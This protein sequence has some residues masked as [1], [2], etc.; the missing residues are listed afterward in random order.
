[1]SVVE[2]TG[3]AGSTSSP[4]GLA[5]EAPSSRTSSQQ[6]AD[7]GEGSESESYVEVEHLGDDSAPGPANFAT[8]PAATSSPP[9]SVVRHI[10]KRTLITIQQRSI[11]EE[12]YRNGMSSASLQ[13][14]HMHDAA[15]ERTGLDL[16]VV[17]V[18][19]QLSNLAFPRPHTV[20]RVQD[21]ALYTDA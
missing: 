4:N 15:A 20:V 19:L 8:V 3:D 18:S 1:M 14:A 10:T 5:H 21:I 11:L 13:L 7:P 6:D 16:S 2:E 17:R 9:S 12:F